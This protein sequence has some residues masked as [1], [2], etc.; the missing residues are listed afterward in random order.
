MS[1][2]TGNIGG[3]NNPIH[4]ALVHLPITLFPISALFR[5]LGTTNIQTNFP[6]ITPEF[7]F[8][9]AHYINALG[10]ICAVPTVITGYCEYKNM[11]KRNKNAVD[12]VDNCIKVERKIVI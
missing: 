6:A 7:S 9:A 10:I 1:F 12:T 8:T 11:S 4:P 5:Y 3:N 2:C